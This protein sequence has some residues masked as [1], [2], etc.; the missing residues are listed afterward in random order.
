MLGASFHTP[1]QQWSGSECGPQGRVWVLLVIMFKYVCPS[2]KGHLSYGGSDCWSGRGWQVMGICTTECPLR[3]S[4]VVDSFCHPFRAQELEGIS[5]AWLDPEGHRAGLAPG[6]PQQAHG[7][8]PALCCGREPIGS[9]GGHC[10]KSRDCPGYAGWPCHLMHVTP[11]CES[12]SVLLVPSLCHA[13]PS[14]PQPPKFLPR[15]STA[16]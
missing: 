15:A 9:W 16:S 12:G 3:S 4:P 7:L 2:I 6:C 1:W 5:L 8:G 14:P 10:L 11:K 13:L